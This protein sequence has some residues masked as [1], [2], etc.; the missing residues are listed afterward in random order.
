[1]SGKVYLVGAGPGDPKLLTLRAVEVLRQCDVV[2]VDKLVGEGVLAHARAGAE[3]IDV[4]KRAGKHSA[5]Q[6]EIHRIMIAAARVGNI[7]VRLKGGDPMV[8]GRGG[9]EIEALDAAGIAWEVVPGVTAATAAAARLGMSLT[10][11]EVASSVAFVTGHGCGP[12]PRPVGCRDADTLVI[13]MGGQRLP[14]IARELIAAGRSPSTPVALV[15]GATGEHENVERCTLGTLASDW[16]RPLDGP[17]LAIVGDVV[18]RSR[19]SG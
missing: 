3:I 1:V 13:Y 16:N 7:V 19:G 11:R 9:E 18:G 12:E 5:A 17:L 2:L 8:F 6:E 4:G 14:A 10:R 15:Q